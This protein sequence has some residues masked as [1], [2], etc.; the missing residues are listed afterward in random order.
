MAFPFVKGDRV[1]HH[2]YG[3]GVILSCGYMCADVR[4]INGLQTTIVTE[5]LSLDRKEK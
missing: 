4:F 3:R 1:R 2:H 5:N